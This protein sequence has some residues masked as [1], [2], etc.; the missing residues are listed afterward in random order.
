MI[1]KKLQKNLTGVLL[2]CTNLF[3]KSLI[4]FDRGTYDKIMLITTELK[5]TLT[6]RQLTSIQYTNR[7]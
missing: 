6:K 4:D 7:Y 5:K 3:Q 1:N 2:P